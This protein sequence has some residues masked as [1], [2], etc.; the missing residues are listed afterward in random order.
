MSCFFSVVIPLYNKQYTIVNTLNSVLKQ[1]FQDFEI[2]IV[3]DGSTDDSVRLI[4]E[5]FTDIRIKVINQQNAGVSAARNRGIEEAQSEWIAFLDGD[6]LWHEDYLQISY[7]AIKANLAA[8]M[9]CSAGIIRS[10]NN[11]KVLAYRLANKYI[12]KIQTVDY[13]ENPC[14]FGHTSATIVRKKLLEKVGGF[15]VGS[16]C[17]EDYAC[18]QSVALLTEVVYIGIP[19]SRYNG[20]VPGQITSIDAE[21]RYQYTKYAVQYRDA[22]MK[23]YSKQNQKKVTFERFFRY[24]MRHAIKVL[25]QTNEIRTFDAFFLNLSTPN[26]KLFNCVERFFYEHHLLWLSVFWINITKV[27]WRVYNYPIVGEKVDIE[28]T[29]EKY[30][31]W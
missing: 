1:T 4:S 31:K 18:F 3:N 15:I 26:K 30:R 27:F 23:V 6:D 17:C 7:S 8:G 29:P 9:V 19:L 28:K 10:L 12:N 16:K 22:V 14:V 25:F 21:T 24:D 11:E 2:V 5:N 13:F 20:G